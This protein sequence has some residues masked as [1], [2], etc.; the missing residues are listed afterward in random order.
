MV[1]VHGNFPNTGLATTSKYNMEHSVVFVSILVSVVVDMAT[2]DRYIVEI[3]GSLLGQSTQDR[4]RNSL[5]IS[6]GT[7]DIHIFITVIH[8][9]FK[10][11]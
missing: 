1:E 11:W 4:F 2:A 7:L 6:R 10:V 9:Y 3:E 8:H 5:V